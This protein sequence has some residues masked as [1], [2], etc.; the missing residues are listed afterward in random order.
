M[1]TWRTP[2]V[3]EIVVS[4]EVTAYMSAELPDERD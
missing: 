4:M 2:K 1:K 3:V